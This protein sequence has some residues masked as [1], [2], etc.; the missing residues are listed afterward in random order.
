[1]GVDIQADNSISG[2]AKDINIQN[3]NNTD[4]NYSKHKKIKISLADVLGN[5]VKNP[6]ILK[7]ESDGKVSFTLATATIDKETKHSTQ[8]T[9]LAFL[10]ASIAGFICTYSFLTTNLISVLPC[11]SLELVVVVSSVTFKQTIAL[12]V[13]PKQ[14]CRLFYSLTNSRIM[15]ADSSLALRLSCLCDA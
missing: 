12:V 5:I 2:N 7:K 8:S 11:S 3:A 1:V 4:T 9:G 6:L 15:R 10:T 13:T 14:P